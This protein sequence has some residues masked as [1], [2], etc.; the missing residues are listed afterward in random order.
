MATQVYPNEGALWLAGVVRTALAASHMNLFQNGTVT[1]SPSTTLA[2]LTA[3]VAD[4]TGY[5]E[6]DIATW[7]A[8][9]L[10]PLGGA[11]IESGLLQFAI[12]APYTVSNTIQGWYLTNAADELVC[13]GDF[14]APR[15]LV[16]A[17]DGI[18]FNVELIFGG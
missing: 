10:N 8:P 5:A 2:Q 13:A 11:S 17:G 9:L 7:F 12:A 16:G 18:P 3:V 1:L 6:Q 15:D 4:Y 14:A